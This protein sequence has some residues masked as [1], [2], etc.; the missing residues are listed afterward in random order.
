[1]DYSLLSNT[2]DGLVEI[3]FTK[4]KKGMCFVTSEGDGKLWRANCD[5]H[6]SPNG[7]AYVLEAENAEFETRGFGISKN[8]LAYA[9]KF[10]MLVEEPKEEL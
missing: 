5:T 6:R 1:M 8:S 4:I 10:Y 3:A 7:D 2:P 9:P